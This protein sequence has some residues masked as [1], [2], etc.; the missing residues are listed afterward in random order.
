MELPEFIGTDWWGEPAEVTEKERGTLGEETDFA[1]RVYTGGLGDQ[2]FVSVVLS[3]N[4]MSKS[5]HR[6]ER[7]LPAQGWTLADSRDVI[8][9]FTG[10][11]G[12]EQQLKVKKLLV[13]RPNIDRNG[14][15]AEPKVRYGVMYYWFAGHTDMTNS[16]FVRM[17]Y[18]NRDRLFKGVNQRWAYVT[19]LIQVTQGLR[20][21]GKDIDQS[22]TVLREVTALVAP[23]IL[24]PTLLR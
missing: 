9:P 1:R 5:I 21:F 13:Q 10:P 6:P 18:D 19:T 20:P 14:K 11:D 15:P 22:E 16:H 3:G 7:C 17:A 23:K 8:L 24:G 12:K 4:D 2:V